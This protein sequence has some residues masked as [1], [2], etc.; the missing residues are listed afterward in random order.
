MIRMLPRMRQTGMKEKLRRAPGERR[1]ALRRHPT[2]RRRATGRY[3][4]LARL[5]ATSTLESTLEAATRGVVDA[6]DAGRAAILVFERSRQQARIL[7]EF[8][9]RPDKPVV[10]PN[11]VV[12]LPGSAAATS[13]YA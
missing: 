1:R 10:Y 9:P 3:G 2:I 12:S 4:L 8:P 5:A 11:V 6:L 13:L 7:A